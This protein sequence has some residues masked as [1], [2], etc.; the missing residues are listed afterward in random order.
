MGVS[1]YRS[2]LV[3]VL[4]S[5]GATAEVYNL[6]LQQTIEVAARQNPDVVLARLDQQRMAAG[7]KIAVDPFRP[8]VYGG[9]GLAYTYGYPNSI[10]GNA[11]SLFQAK[12]DM[13]LYN[14]P[15]AYTVA[16]S[17]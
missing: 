14:K 11:P 9:S 1:M 5:A 12:T 8:K 10:E 7:V 2:A 13:A 6:N 16:A 3:L 4:A 15:K 17:R